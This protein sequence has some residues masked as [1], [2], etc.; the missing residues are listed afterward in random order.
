MPSASLDLLAPRL[1]NIEVGMLRMML[2][3]LLNYG[4][5]RVHGERQRIAEASL[6]RSGQALH[7]C[8]IVQSGGVYWYFH[9]IL[10]FKKHIVHFSLSVIKFSFGSQLTRMNLIPVGS[11]G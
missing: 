6:P 8:L 1:F 3:P 7:G 2:L 5:V 10:I 9:R 4:Q 11:W